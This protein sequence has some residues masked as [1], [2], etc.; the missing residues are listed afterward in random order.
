M[1]NIYLLRH[2][3][4]NGAAAL[5]GKTDIDVSSTIDDEILKTL[6]NR[7]DKFELVL[8]SPLKRCLSLAQN[9]SRETGKPIVLINAMQEMDFG[10]YDGRAFDD[11][12]YI[13]PS[14]KDKGDSEQK[15]W[16]DLE[17]FWQNPAEYSLPNAEQLSDFHQR[18]KHA[19]NT[20]L[21][22]YKDE[23]ILLTTHGG[24]IR[25]ILA[26][27]LDL[28]WKNAKLFNQLHI[29]NASITHIHTSTF[30]TNT[31]N[32]RALDTNNLD[33]KVRAIGM[34]LS[35]LTADE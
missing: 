22:K 19:W 18:V 5:Y 21:T 6:I 1:S 13:D 35:G 8:T 16:A 17:K 15:P 23:N 7:Q 11:I 24:V 25:M 29:G 2:G 32:T 12:P 28:N 10:E 27:V 14:C 30:D 34:P 3:K 33:I 20:V 31:S 26:D 9:F 4:V